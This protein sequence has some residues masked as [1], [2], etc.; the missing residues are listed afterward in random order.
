MLETF[1]RELIFK[2]LAQPIGRTLFVEL[3]NYQPGSDTLAPPPPPAASG[4]RT[5]VMHQ[6]NMAPPV[7]VMPPTMTHGHAHPPAP[8]HAHHE[9]IMH[10]PPVNQTIYSPSA[11][12][13]PPPPPNQQLAPPPWSR[14]GTVTT[15]AMPPQ[16]QRR[17]ANGERSRGGTPQP[18]AT[19]K[20][21]HPE[22][23]EAASARSSR[24]SSSAS[25]VHQ[26]KRR[27]TTGPSSTP[28]APASASAPIAGPSVYGTP[29]GMPLPIPSHPVAPPPVTHSPVS[30]LPR[31]M[32][33]LSPSLAMIVSPTNEPPMTSPRTSYH[34]T[35]HSP[36]L[37][38]VKSLIAG[39][40]LAR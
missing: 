14:W 38:P 28:T 20:R 7:A 22:G 19:R 16:T 29:T 15:P 21:K 9:Q 40:E 35:A 10:L 25:A 32:Q 12:Q 5:G 33:T 39:G 3:V 13:P 11:L 27:A 34:G 37:P 2:K 17:V 31:P 1:S 23:D 26:T 6:H 4:S 30:P 36:S 24:S 18:S 8:A